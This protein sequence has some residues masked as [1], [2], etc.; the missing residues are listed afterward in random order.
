MSNENSE[1]QTFKDPLTLIKGL[2]DATILDFWKWAY[3]DIL[4]NRNRSIFAEF[5]VGH[6]LGVLDN[7]REEWAPYDFEYNGKKIEV[8]SAAF[9]QS[10]EQEK[11]S[12]ISFDISKKQ[13]LDDE[14]IYF[15]GETIR[16]ADIYVFCLF[17]DMNLDSADVLNLDSWLFYIIPTHHID[18]KF[19]DQKNVTLNRIKESCSPVK[20]HEVKGVIDIISKILPE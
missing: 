11:P 16:P 5:I 13:E 2:S 20:C 10:W 3:S 17:S 14:G 6:L 19:G 15:T 9:V 8:K 12:K 1:N 18:E 4:T 7:P